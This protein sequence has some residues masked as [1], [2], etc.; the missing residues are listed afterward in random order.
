MQTDRQTDIHTDR[1]TDIQT[2]KQTNSQTDLI[3]LLINVDLYAE[4][5]L[6]LIITHIY[7]KKIKLY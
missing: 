6:N 7:K 5:N 3:H 4:I 2:D 1:Q